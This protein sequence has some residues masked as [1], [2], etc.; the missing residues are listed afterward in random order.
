V[1]VLIVEDNT[2]M[3]RAIEKSL[4][5]HGHAISLVH[6]AAAARAESTS[7]DVGVFDISL[8]DGDGVE[9]AEQ[10]LAERRVRHVLFFSGAVDDYMIDRAQVTGRVLPKDQS[11]SELHRVILELAKG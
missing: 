3:A 5:V 9:L 11:F 6:S 10:L 7:F 1:R 2:A 4:R 8:P